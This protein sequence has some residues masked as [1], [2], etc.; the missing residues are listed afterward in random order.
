AVRDARFLQIAIKVDDRSK[1]KFY[2]RFNENRWIGYSNEKDSG[3]SR[4][5]PEYWIR[6][7]E[8]GPADL[9]R[10]ITRDIHKD[11]ART[12]HLEGNDCNR[13]EAVRFRGGF[14]LLLLRII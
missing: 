1:F 11:L 9:V 12:W 7:P 13:I 5:D 3:K 10:F 6:V 4:H 8:L 14:G 2:I